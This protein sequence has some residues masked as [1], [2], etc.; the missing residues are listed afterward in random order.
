MNTMSCESDMRSLLMALT[1]NPAERRR[2]QNRLAKRKSQT[3]KSRYSR[4]Q[5]KKCR[6]SRRSIKPC[7]VIIHSK[8]S[9]ND[10]EDLT[11]TATLADPFGSLQTPPHEPTQD[12]GQ[13]AVIFPASEMGVSGEAAPRTLQQNAVTDDLDASS[14]SAGIPHSLNTVE[15]IEPWILDASMTL[16][17]PNSRHEDMSDLSTEDILTLGF[18]RPTQGSP[19]HIAATHGHINVAKTLILHGSDVNAPDKAGLAPIH[20][21]TQNNQGP[22]VTMLAEHGADVD[23]LDPDGCT[24]LYRAAESGNKAMVERLLRHGAKLS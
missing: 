21:A 5:G 10:E 17:T 8:I 4:S 22:M 15:F 1:V 13:A 6:S 7:R 23:F 19:L 24:P 3:N 18:A 20:Y 16:M 14:Y 9:N 11:Y 2:T 12:F